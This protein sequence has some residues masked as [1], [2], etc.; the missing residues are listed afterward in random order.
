MRG[1]G[2]AGYG[3]NMMH[4]QAGLAYAEAAATRAAFAQLAWSQPMAPMVT[5]AAY[6]A[7]RYTPGYAPGYTPDYYAGGQSYYYPQQWTQYAAPYQ[8]H[9]RPYHPHHARYRGYAGSA[10]SYAYYGDQSYAYSPQSS[11]AAYSPEYGYASGGYGQYS[12]SYD[13]GRRY[14]RNYRRTNEEDYGDYDGYHGRTYDSQRRPDTRYA[15]YNAKIVA[16]VAREMGFT[17]QQTLACIATMLVESRG[18][19]HQIGDHGHSVGLF[20]LNDRGEG[21][22]MTMGQRMDPVINARRAL[23]EFRRCGFYGNPGS[24]AATAQRPRNRGQFA[25]MVNSMLPAANRL[26]ESADSSSYMA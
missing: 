26:L 10:P 4:S 24:W 12:R 17:R 11:A 18:D 1:H 14:D 25:Y 21:A 5:P 22:G 2:L 13:Y 23:H 6:Y 19:A 7:P 15:A 8:Q 3:E 20:Q 16:A 9:H